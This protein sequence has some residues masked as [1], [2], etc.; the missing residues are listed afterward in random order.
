MA[1]PLTAERRW[2]VDAIRKSVPD[3]RY[4]AEHIPGARAQ[5][6]AEQGHGSIVEPFDEVMDALLQDA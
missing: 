4:Y 5:I 6:L 2:T 3:G 1:C